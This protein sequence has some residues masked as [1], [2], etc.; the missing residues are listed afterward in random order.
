MQGGAR[1]RRAVW[2]ILGAVV[3]TGGTTAARAEGDAAALAADVAAQARA[4]GVPEEPLLRKVREG[5]AK[6]VP[7]ERIKSVTDTMRERLVRAR[8]ACGGFVD[9]AACT[10]AVAE[11]L[12]AGVPIERMT[13]ALEAWAPAI[14]ER[15]R[16]RATFAVGD[17]AERQTDVDDAVALVELAIERG[18]RG[19]DIAGLGEHVAAAARRSGRTMAAEVA[20]LLATIRSDP[21]WRPRGLG[22]VRGDHDEKQERGARPEFTPPGKGGTAPG[23]AGTSSGLGLGRDREGSGGVTRGR[24]DDAGRR[25]EENRRGGRPANPGGGKPD[26]DDDKPPNDHDQ[27]GNGRGGN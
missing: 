20:Q 10:V 4:A 8:G 12:A 23:R 6:G 13:R 18:G 11:T 25:A 22:G 26:R 19:A 3:A 14:D 27:R 24:S 1:M 21:D 16:L 15:E 9:E 7:T 17:L 5:F 2:S